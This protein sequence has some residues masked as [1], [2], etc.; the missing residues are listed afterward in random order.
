MRVFFP[1]G[2]REGT[3]GVKKTHPP[4]IHI[5]VSA[6]QDFL[7]AQYPQMVAEGQPTVSSLMWALAKKHPKEFL[8]DPADAGSVVR[9]TDLRKLALSVLAQQCGIP[10]PEG[11]AVAAFQAWHDA[12]H[13]VQDLLFPGA[14]ELLQRLKAK[15]VRLCAVTNGN[16]DISRIAAF[17]G[18]F[19]FC[20]NAEKVGARKRTGRPYV[21]AVK[22]AGLGADVGGRWVHIGDDFTEDIV[23]AKNGDLKLR[24]IWYHT[25]ERKAKVEREQ[26]EKRRQQAPLGETTTATTKKKEEEKA[27]AAP[28]APGLGPL[29]SIATASEDR[30]FQDKGA[31][32]VS[33]M[34]TDDYLAHFIVKE[35]A[36]AEVETLEEAGAVIEAWLGAEPGGRGGGKR[37]EAAQM[38][39]PEPPPP[40]VAAAGDGDGKAD[41]K[42][43]IV[44]RE[45]LP[46]RAKFCS[47]CGESQG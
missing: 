18:V 15:G 23:A 37:T 27:A 34:E 3:L 25:A 26:A 6:L 33:T 29:A 39:P 13:D 42:F 20:I 4:H 46:R 38:A 31:V 14:V 17:E 22:A 11:V 2:E 9:F 45:I 41:T 19:E 47:S 24:T 32:Q 30:Y 43:C 21:A 36:D 28:L 16:C 40:V 7:A 10:D 44:C 5:Y 8:E 35:F 1:R 12:R